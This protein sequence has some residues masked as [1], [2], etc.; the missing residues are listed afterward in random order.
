[1]SSGNYIEINEKEVMEE[2][3]NQLSFPLTDFF[4]DLKEKMNCNGY[5]ILNNT[6]KETNSD[7]L[8][9]ILYNIKLEKL[10][11]YKETNVY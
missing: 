8:E 11:K 1:M 4:S 10:A 6:N 2:Y 5:N 9:L 7:F 3:Y